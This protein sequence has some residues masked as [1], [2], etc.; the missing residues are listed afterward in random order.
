MVSSVFISGRLGRSIDRQ[1]RMVELDSPI[2]SKGEF[3]ICEIPV[4]CN[5]SWKASFFSAKVGTLIVLKGRLESEEPLGLYVA[6][7]IEEL[8]PF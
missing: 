1:T 8:F 7:E 2:P 3:R 5:R 4:R 6:L